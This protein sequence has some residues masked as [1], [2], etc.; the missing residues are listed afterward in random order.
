MW[1]GMLISPTCVSCRWCW[2]TDLFR[3]IYRAKFVLRPGRDNISWRTIMVLGHISCIWIQKDYSIKKEVYKL[4]EGEVD[5][6]EQWYTELGFR[7]EGIIWK[8][9]VFWLESVHFT[10]V[11][12]CWGWLKTV[13]LIIY[14]SSTCKARPS[15]TWM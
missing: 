11:V 2:E 9:F 4:A 3:E 6:T 14:V 8:H 15:T 10:K 7:P 1:Q 13:E 12:V 5:L